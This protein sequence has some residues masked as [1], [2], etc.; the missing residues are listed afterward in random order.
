MNAT[1]TCNQDAK[2][3]CTTS[4]S[5]FGNPLCQKRFTHRLLLNNHLERAHKI[6]SQKSKQIITLNNRS[7]F[8][9]PLMQEKIW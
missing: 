1:I 6:D 2:D 8:I 3:T 9:L 4:D 7:G 5:E